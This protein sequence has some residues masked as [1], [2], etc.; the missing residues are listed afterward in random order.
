MIGCW[1]DGERICMDA[2]MHGG[3]QSCNHA[4]MQSCI[5]LT[6]DPLL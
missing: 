3:M 5:H 4:V 1:G 2:W 6:H